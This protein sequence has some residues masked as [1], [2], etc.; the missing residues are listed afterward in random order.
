MPFNSFNVHVFYK[1]PKHQT[2][3][4]ISTNSVTM[5]KAVLLVVLALFFA[6]ISVSQA[7]ELTVC[8]VVNAITDYGTFEGDDIR[9]L[10]RTPTPLA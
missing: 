7:R 4:I 5:K 1:D 10:V 6:A 8:E 3:S 2:N 9:K